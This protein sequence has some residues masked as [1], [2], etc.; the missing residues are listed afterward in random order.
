MFAGRLKSMA[1]PSWRMA[2]KGPR[3]LHDSFQR[4]D[5]LV[6]EMR[7]SQLMMQRPRLMV[8]SWRLMRSPAGPY[9]G[10]PTHDF[11]FLAAPRRK[12]GKAR[13]E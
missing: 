2:E 9:S 10:T 1:D 5:K 12:D 11:K 3:K 4:M 7:A 6:S 8:P 13:P